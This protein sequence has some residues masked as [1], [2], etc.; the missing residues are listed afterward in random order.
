LLTGNSGEKL[1]LMAQIADKIPRKK[2]SPKKKE[3]QTE[4]C[5]IILYL[6]TE[7]SIHLKANSIY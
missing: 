2:L 4:L 7:K 5:F 1:A 3:Q 6:S